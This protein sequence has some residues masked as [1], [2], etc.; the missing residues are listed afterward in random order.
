MK[1]GKR[2]KGEVMIEGL[3]IVIMT[4]LL[5]L[6][7]LAV[8]F[9]HYQ[10]YIMTVVTNDAAKKVAATYN[11][12]TS[13]MVMGYIEVRDLSARDLYRSLDT[14]ELRTVN[15]DRVSSY[16]SYMLN[17][18]GSSDMINKVDVKLD[19]NVDNISASRGH[20]IVTAQCTFHTPLDAA[21][22]FFGMDS[23]VKYECVSYA[24]CQDLSNYISTTDFVA[25][26][27]SF[28]DSKLAKL[29][30]SV[31]KILFKREFQKT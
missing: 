29:I 22:E 20:V 18:L 26:Q 31:F 13:D 15:Q 27:M 25:G 6:W 12:P 24:E 8:G 9:L 5:L 16:I 14:D 3:I 2:E 23:I 4:I 1:I 19:F 7:I 10:R 30:N 28:D 17:K 11:N 21:L